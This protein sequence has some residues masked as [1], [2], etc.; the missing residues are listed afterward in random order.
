MKRPPR[1]LHCPWNVAGNPASLA[2]AERGVGLRSH[3]VQ[4]TGSRYQFQADETL[5]PPGV[6]S[7]MQEVYRWRLLWRAVREY[8]IIH[9]N[10]GQSILMGQ[11]YPDR[12][13]TRSGSWRGRLL[14]RYWSSCWMADLPLLKRLGKGIVMTYQGDDARQ[15]DECRR[16][17]AIT[18]ANVVGADY[19]SAVTDEWKRRAIAQVAQYAD[20]I[21]ALNPDLLHVLPRNARF[22]PYA[23]ID[24]G[25]WVPRPVPGNPVP[26]IVHA[27]THRQAKGTHFIVQAVERLRREAIPCEFVLVENMTQEE[28]RKT[29]ERA[30][31]LVDQLLVGWY[32]GVAVECMAL[33]KPVVCYVREEDL[34]FVPEAMRRALPVVNATPE[35]IYDTLKA[36]LTTRRA[37]LPELG[38]RGR[39]YVETWHNPARIAHEVAEDYQ[40]IWESKRRPV[41]RSEQSRPVTVVSV[42]PLPLGR[43]SRTLKQAMTLARHGYRS[44]VLADC[45]RWE[46]SPEPPLDFSSGPVGGSKQDAPRGGR[47]CWGWLARNGL[48]QRLYFPVWLLVFAYRYVWRLYVRLPSASLF[49]MHE[50]SS[51]PAVWLASRWGRVPVIYDAHDFYSGMETEAER[52]EFTRRYIKPFQLRLERACIARAASVF[53]VS[54]GV[55]NLLHREFRAKPVVLRNCHD[56]RLDRAVGQGLRHRL[57][58]H[59]DTFLLVVIGNHK[60]GQNIPGALEALVKLPQS[61]H[62][63]LVGDGYSV[64][65]DAIRELG[66]AERVHLAG[67]L[68]PDQLVPAVRGAD[69]SLISYY[70]RSINYSAALP[71]KLFQSLAAELPILYPNLPE[72]A[73]LMQA[74]GAGICVDPQE[75]SSIVSAVRRLLVDPDAAGTKE[76]RRAM[77][78]RYTWEAEE[79]TLL[80]QVREAVGQNRKNRSCA[81]S[82]AF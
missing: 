28:A 58:L 17:F 21:Y 25:D 4:L 51:F 73:A 12:S 79:H 6:S 27:P 41:S 43:D 30:D 47:I 5:F 18:A 31:L 32:G 36:L 55:A 70:P 24:P 68:P 46:L 49:Y 82:Q 22:L 54:D 76:Q 65:C 59:N 20:R 14:E 44:I 77:K 39:A 52:S 81:E 60:N 63:A 71:N 53:T 34:T 42:T 33:Q 38:R 69:A 61:V 26:V 8:D 9:F 7:L 37:E 29:Y 35:T 74:Q 16:R 57:G 72:I 56:A 75:P 11:A 23:N 1:V 13:R 64:Y 50:F 78:H 3:S 2:R 62:L 19:Y 48:V 67:F 45:R 80:N 10:F 40:A 15:G 66:L